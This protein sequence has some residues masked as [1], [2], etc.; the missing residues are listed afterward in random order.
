MRI[1]TLYL[2]GVGTCIPPRIPTAQAVAAGN[3]AANEAEASG[4]VALPVAGSTPAPD[5]AVQA[6]DIALRQSGHVPADFG[7]LMHSSVHF[8]GPDG[9]A[10]QHYILRKTLNMPISALEIRNGCMGML[11]ALEAA[12]HRL[13]ANPAKDA[14]LLTAAD[15][16]GTRLADRWNASRLFLLGD[17][18]SA[19]VL[20]RRGGFARLLS[21]GF[22]SNPEMEALNRGGERLFPP[23]P[24]EGHTLN[25]EER[26]AWWREAWKRGTPPPTGH[27]GDLVAEATKIAL[28]HAGTAMDELKR[29]VHIGFSYG[30]LKDCFLD[31][32]AITPEQGTWEFTR[33][34]GHMGP[35]DPAAG[36]EYLWSTGQAV[37]GDRLLVVASAP[38]MEAGAAVIEITAPA[39]VA[40]GGNRA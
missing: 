14:I 3:Y 24:T 1:G 36:I 34:T 21:T 40:E 20:S 6:A 7:A 35:S 17:A 15:N 32:L 11:T 37:P 28:T 16:F 10:A 13:L 33:T 23:G 27:M 19:L 12:A 39:P 9:W 30:P 8:Q 5:L 22:V 29:V 25:L 38:G 4:I 2:A 18:G 31:P 26:R